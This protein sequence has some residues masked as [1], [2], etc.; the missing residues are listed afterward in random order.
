[1]RRRSHH[2]RH[3][4]V[5]RVGP[6]QLWYLRYLHALLVEARLTRSILT[7]SARLLAKIA[8]EIEPEPPKPVPT[9]FHLTLEDIPERA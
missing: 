8:R 2:P 1:M 9:S 5:R 3:R 4:R 7:R 6:A